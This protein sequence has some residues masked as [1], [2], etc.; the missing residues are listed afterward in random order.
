[1][2]LYHVRMDVSLPDDLDPAERE[3]LVSTE[4]RYCHELQSAGKWPHIWR[5]VGA[6]SNI[7][8]FDVDSPT[9]L[10]DILWGLPL[11]RYMVVT[12]TPLSKHP[13]DILSD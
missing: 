4:R 12:V 1:M 3:T 7:S 11:F 8:I 13:S 5:I 6:Y 2:A 9:E 10:H